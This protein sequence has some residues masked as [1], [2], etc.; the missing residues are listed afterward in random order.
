VDELIAAD[1]DADV[2]GSGR[3]RGEEDEIAHRKV[4]RLD[5]LPQ[6]SLLLDVARQRDAVLREDIL[7]EAAAVE[8]AGI[9]LNPM[10]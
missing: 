9:F 2:G 4:A 7:R 1:R 6:S 5:L 8:T 3:D 10:S